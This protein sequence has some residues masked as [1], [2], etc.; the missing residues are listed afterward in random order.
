M[1]ARNPPAG[2]VAGAWLDVTGRARY[3]VARPLGRH[4]ALT[5]P[6]TRAIIVFRTAEEPGGVLLQ[7]VVSPNQLWSKSADGAS[8]DP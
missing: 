8:N 4:G 3:A 2:H 5:F 7:P 1:V 6:V